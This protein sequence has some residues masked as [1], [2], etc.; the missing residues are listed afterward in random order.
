MVWSDPEIKKLSKEFVTVADEA[1]YLYP[2]NPQH[3]ERAGSREDHRFFRK[4]GEQ[5]PPGDW[6]RGTK[7]GIYM[8][9]PNSEYLEGRFAAS[10]EPE[11]IKARLRRALTRWDTLRKDK[12]Y[13][14]KPI[15]IKPWTPPPDVVGE[16]ILRVNTRDLPRGPGDKSGARRHEIGQSGMWLDF[17]K[18]AWNENWFA[19]EKA[20]ALVPKG[21]GSEPIDPAIVRRMASEVLI[22]NVRGQT[23]E[24]RADEVKVAAMSMKRL[25]S[26]R[27]EYTGSVSMSAGSR[28]FDGKLYGQGSWS[29]SKFTELDIVVIGTRRG[30][31]NFNQRERDPGPAPMG[32]TLSLRRK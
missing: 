11:D 31:G 28:G 24:W 7:Q 8:M 6:N 10:S 29:G 12:G 23:A 4:F 30:A 2:E 21:S 22:D 16:L 1:Y 14:N 25:P 20:Q 18:W 32:I 27:I 5:M 13:A 15:P 9:G 17:V 26:G 19:I 3:L